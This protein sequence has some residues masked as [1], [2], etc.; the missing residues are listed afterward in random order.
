MLWASV[1]LPTLYCPI[2]NITTAPSP[3][4]DTILVL[5]MV[6]NK[7]IQKNYWN[8]FRFT[9]LPYS[10]MDNWS[11]CLHG[12]QENKSL[13]W[14]ASNFLYA[15]KISW[16]STVVLGHVSFTHHTERQQS[17]FLIPPR[18][19]LPGAGAQEKLSNPELWWA[20]DLGTNSEM[21]ALGPKFKTFTSYDDASNSFWNTA[22]YR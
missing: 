8:M 5:I 18:A 3:W 2:F 1:H 14:E 16:K 4:P 17:Y 6:Y 20:K 10:K 11:S 19:T 12:P 21:F 7:K 9:P 13:F 15:N 22:S